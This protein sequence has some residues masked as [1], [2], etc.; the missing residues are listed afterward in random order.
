M[1][2]PRVWPVSTV[3]ELR[4]LNMPPNDYT[5]PAV[6]QARPLRSIL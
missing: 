4:G 3:G 2:K 6:C 5:A 1:F